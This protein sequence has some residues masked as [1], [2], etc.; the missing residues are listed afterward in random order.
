MDAFQLVSLWKTEKDSYLSSLRQSDGLA[1]RQIQEIG[2][3]FEQ[4]EKLWGALDTAL[5]DVLYTLLLGL[6]GSAQIGG[7]QET[8]QIR[9]EAGNLISNCGEIEA[10]AYEQF[11]AGA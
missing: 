3:S 2:L 6:D 9:D 5:T 4:H 8:F 10:A 1:A 7:V 11:H